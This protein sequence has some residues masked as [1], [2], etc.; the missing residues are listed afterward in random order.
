MEIYSNKDVYNL[1]SNIKFK[2]N[3]AVLPQ[4]IWELIFRLK[5][6][7]E[8]REMYDFLVFN[9]DLNQCRILHRT[10][11]R[12]GT[13][14]I[15]TQNIANT[16]RIEAHN[17]ILKFNDGKLKIIKMLELLSEFIYKWYFWIYDHSYI[18]TW[19][20]LWCTLKVKAQEFYGQIYAYNYYQDNTNKFKD[21]EEYL[22]AQDLIFDITV[23]IDTY[24][25][26][27]TSYFN[28]YRKNNRNNYFL[29]ANNKNKYIYNSNDYKY[30][31]ACYVDQDDYN[32]DIKSM[33]E[34][35]LYI[36][37]REYYNTVYDYYMRLRSG[38]RKIPVGHHPKVVWYLDRARLRFY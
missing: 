21:Y 25:P 30:F 34:F 10:R 24:H 19:C 3:M 1:I 11:G 16:L 14:H 27:K 35:E 17:F 2:K 20:R 37:F 15:Y 9:H 33:L 7:L 8:N 28:E 23:F 4:E 36:Y 22:Y 6:H 13:V 5:Y 32:K 29:A 12:N 18:P 26:H 31:S 38:N